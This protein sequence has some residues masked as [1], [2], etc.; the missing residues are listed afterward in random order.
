VEA[1]SS[2]LSRVDDTGELEGVPTSRR[3]PRLNHLFFIDDSQLFCQADLGHWNRL[4]TLLHTY[5]LASGQRLNSSKTTIY[6]SRNTNAESRQEILDVTGITSSQRYDTY[7]GLPA[8]VGKYRTKEFKGIVDRVRSR[9]QDW[10][11]K[12]LSQAGWEILLKAV[13]QAIPTYC[14]SVFMLPKTLCSKINILMQSFWWG[15]SGIHWMKWSK[16]GAPKSRGGMGFRDLVWFNK[17]LL[18]KQA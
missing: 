3:G 17:A 13:I 8:L 10:K 5:E 4:S 15:T 18:A 1:L 11:H 6:F 16:M 7:L 12:F 9:L 2:L 14:M